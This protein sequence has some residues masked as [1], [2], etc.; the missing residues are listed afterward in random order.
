MIELVL[1]IIVVLT[2]AI[3]IVVITIPVAIKSYD[4]NRIRV[5]LI[6]I[7]TV[8]LIVV[9][10]RMVEVVVT[11]FGRWRKLGVWQFEKARTRVNAQRTRERRAEENSGGE[12]T[13]DA[14]RYT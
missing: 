9:L 12:F 8:F 2:V 3:L 10:M 6:V 14:M 7:R 1:V 5:N 4:S 13:G 11:V